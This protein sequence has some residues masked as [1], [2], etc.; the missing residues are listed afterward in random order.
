[1]DV[2]ISLG[3]E[4]ERLGEEEERGLGPE[5]PTVGSGRRS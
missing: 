4:E 2:G 1:M 5:L 3:K